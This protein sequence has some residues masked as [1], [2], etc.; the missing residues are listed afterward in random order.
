[1]GPVRLGYGTVVAAGAVV[2]E[3]I[4]ED[5]TLVI[6]G[7]HDPEK[8]EFQPHTYR[9]LARVVRNNLLYL[10]NL[11]AL[12]NWYREVREPFLGRQAMGALV[13]AGALAV[14]GSAK[15]ERM[16]RLTAMAEKVPVSQPAGREFH[17]RAADVCALFAGEPPVPDGEH[18]L[19]A[20]RLAAADSPDDYIKTIKNLAPDLKRQGVD[21]LQQ[22]V[23]VLCEEAGALLKSMELFGN[24]PWIHCWEET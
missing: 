10:A 24:D 12:E 23:E 16:K 18:F 2:R 15:E 20:F 8:R 3:D 9:N 21:W 6:V 14:L 19:A 7:P 1:M 22:I 4:T 13:Y 17:E 5:R 11:V